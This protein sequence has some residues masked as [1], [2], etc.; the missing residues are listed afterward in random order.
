MKTWKS[1]LL[2]VVALAGCGGSDSG[3]EEGNL[4]AQIPLG[5]VEFTCKTTGKFEGAKTHTVKFTID[6]ARKSLSKK[7][8]EIFS[9]FEQDEDDYSI[10]DVTPESSKLEALNENSGAQLKKDRLVIDGDSD[11]FYLVELVLYRN[12]GFKNGYV[13]LVD[14]GEG[15]GDQYSKISCTQKTVGTAAQSPGELVGKL[16]DLWDTADYEAPVRVDLGPFSTTSS[17][18]VKM[19]EDFLAEAHPDEDPSEFEI[20]PE[21]ESFETDVQKLGLVSYEV[22]KAQVEGSI[23]YYF[24]NWEDV[25]DVAKRV[26][27]AGTL[28]KSLRD[29][30]AKFGFYGWDQH[31]CAAPTNVLLVLS[32]ANKKV[33]AVE[34][35]PCSES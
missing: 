33:W 18:P 13:K 28:M 30:G 31:G 17:E 29:G 26:E 27:T 25:T 9:K 20:L 22:A 21:A 14:S 3:S 5:N 35:E 23:E 16:T 10:V 2:I 32:P 19:L 24:E 4:T 8:G 15:I 6:D 12:S 11:G 34:L 7:S 1:S